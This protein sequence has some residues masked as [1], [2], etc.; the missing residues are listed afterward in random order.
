MQQYVILLNQTIE[1]TPQ[2]LF[3]S[4]TLYRWKE[5]P[6]EIIRDRSAFSLKR[7]FYVLCLL[8]ISV[9]FINIEKV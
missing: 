9:N 7:G 3:R 5:D 4:A 1:L 6:I 8:R 2:Q